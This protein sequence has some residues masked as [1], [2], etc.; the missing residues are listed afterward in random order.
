MING[1][2]FIVGSGC[3]YNCIFCHH[4]GYQNTSYDSKEEEKLKQI[5][6][7]AKANKIKDISI[8]GGEPFLYWNRLNSLLKLYGND[9]S[10]RIT[11]NSNFTV[12]DKHFDDVKDYNN[13]EYHI[14]FSSLNSS[15]HENIIKKQYLEKLKQNLADFKSI[16]NSRICLNI[17]VLGG[18]N[19]DELVNIFNY[20]KENGFKARFLVLLPM[21]EDMK[22]YYYDID[23]II[24]HFPNAKVL[25]KYSYGRYDITTDIGDF[26]IVK[27]LC[28]EKECQTC[29]KT[30]Y[31]HITPDLKLKPCMLNEQ[32]FDIDFTNQKTVEES[33][34]AVV[35]KLQPW[36]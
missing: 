36:I 27:C 13:I 26:E 25:Q 15:T 23:Q 18:I 28:I 32:S 1:L 24:S 20:C 29:K 33:F 17:P 22:Q 19:S 31:I 34:D 21:N 5:Y 4:E 35:R 9:E 2:R 7:F 30:T 8:T 6:D 10:F 12:A 16:S 14:N 11:L 3:N